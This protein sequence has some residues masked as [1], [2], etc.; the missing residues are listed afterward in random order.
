MLILMAQFTYK[1]NIFIRNPPSN[2]Q[3]H[4]MLIEIHGSVYFVESSPLILWSE[5]VMTVAIVIFAGFVLIMQIRRLGERR[6]NERATG[7]NDNKRC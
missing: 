6:H 4:M 2:G 5:I 1:F 7:V 3:T